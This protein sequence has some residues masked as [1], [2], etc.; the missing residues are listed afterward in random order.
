MFVELNAGYIGG[1]SLRILS[2][3]TLVMYPLWGVYCSSIKKIK[4]DLSSG[5]RVL[6]LRSWLPHLAKYTWAGYVPVRCLFPYTEY[7]HKRVLSFRG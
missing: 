2:S 5:G 6:G 7:S 1:F 4:K 3:C